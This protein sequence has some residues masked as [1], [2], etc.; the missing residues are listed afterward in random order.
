MAKNFQAGYPSKVIWRMA[1]K[2]EDI[3]DRLMPSIDTCFT[4]PNND[5]IINVTY[6]KI[7]RM[8]VGD[9]IKE[10]KKIPD[11]TLPV[12]LP[13]NRKHNKPVGQ[14]VSYQGTVTPLSSN[15]STAAVKMT[16]AE[17]DQ[18]VIDRCALAD[19]CESKAIQCIETN[20]NRVTSYEGE[21]EL[22]MTIHVTTKHFGFGGI[23]LTQPSIDAIKRFVQEAMDDGPDTNTLKVT[24][25]DMFTA[26]ARRWGFNMVFKVTISE[27]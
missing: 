15:Y 16:K 9:V 10:L 14:I 6:L 18:Y 4:D 3:Q 17:Y 23:P 8:S 2:N 20:V 27:K 22:P 11:K 21:Y 1:R 24:I 25:D 26:Y 7:K 19:I 12:T 13:L 5:N